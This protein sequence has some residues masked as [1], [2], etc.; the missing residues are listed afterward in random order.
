[1]KIRFYVNL[2]RAGNSLVQYLLDYR[3]F[4]VYCYEKCVGELCPHNEQT[5]QIVLFMYNSLF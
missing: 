2:H 5:E 4:I 3:Q 1:M